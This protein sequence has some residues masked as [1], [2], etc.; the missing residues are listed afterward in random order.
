MIAMP[1]IDLREG[2]CVQLVGGDYGAERVRLG[3]PLAVAGAWAAHGFRSLHVVDLDAARGRG[4]N[5]T[6]VRRLAACGLEVQAGG[7]VRNEAGIDGLLAAGARRVV[8]GTRALEDPVWLAAADARYPERLI[9]ALDLQGEALLTHG[10]QRSSARSPREVIAALEPLPLAG[11]LVT[12]VHR[13]GRLAGPDLPL[14]ESV[15]RR[16]RQPVQAAGGIA[17]VE[18]LRSLARCGCGAAVLGMAL[19]T[20]RLDPGAVAREFA[21]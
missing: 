4:S 9:V 2:A 8:V 19:Y 10:W 21:A 17:S 7:G 3:D 16:T 11:L 14:L 1:A 12:A 18:D 5:R 20:H 6:L 15:A 13:E